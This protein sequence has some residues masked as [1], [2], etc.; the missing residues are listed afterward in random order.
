MPAWTTTEA[1]AVLRTVSGSWRRMS[2]LR[3]ETD[4]GKR[5]NIFEDGGGGRALIDV[6]KAMAAVNERQPDVIAD[7]VGDVLIEGML[8]EVERLLG[9]GTGDAEAAAAGA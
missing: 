5:W 2:R 9:G 1:N 8:V 3:R 7:I 4:I 6:G